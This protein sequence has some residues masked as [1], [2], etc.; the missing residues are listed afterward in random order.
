M[1]ELPSVKYSCGLVGLMQGM[2]KKYDGH[3][4]C[5]IKTTNIK[6]N[7]GLKFK[8]SS[9]VGHVSCQNLQFVYYVKNDAYNETNW[10]GGTKNCIERGK[11]LQNDIAL[12]CRHCKFPLKCIARCLIIMYYVLHQ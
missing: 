7:D 2:D 3:F 1:F 9:Y 10:E 8:H 5:K 6:N 12:L 11:E 4:W